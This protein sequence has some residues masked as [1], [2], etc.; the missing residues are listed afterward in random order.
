MEQIN[1]IKPM[2]FNQIEH[3]KI[4]GQV[5]RFLGITNHL[6]SF[7]SELS[8]QNKNLYDVLKTEVQ[9]EWNHVQSTTIRKFKNKN[10][11][12]IPKISKVLQHSHRV[13][14]YFVYVL[15]PRLVGVVNVASRTRDSANQSNLANSFLIH[16]AV[17]I[18]RFFCAA[19]CFNIHSD[20]S[21]LFPLKCIEIQ[22]TFDGSKLAAVGRITTAATF[23]AKT[24]SITFMINQSLQQNL[25]LEVGWDGT[26][27]PVKDLICE[28]IR[29]SPPCIQKT[30]ELNIAHALNEIQTAKLKG[31]I[32]A[33]P[34]YK[35]KLQGL[36][37]KIHSEKEL[38]LFL[39]FC[40]G[41]SASEANRLPPGVVAREPLLVN[42]F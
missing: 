23:T 38:L 26:F 40:F 36:G 22:C 6:D 32:L 4:S 24:S 11:M 27:G 13:T 25:Y 29:T 7:I 39:R 42:S 35:T 12:L 33:I 31:G 21:H 16:R 1:M 9:C 14:L 18:Q 15:F 2:A 5:L 19:V 17:S 37:A 34:S 3:D 20:D 30:I 8:I 41:L 10:Y 28:N